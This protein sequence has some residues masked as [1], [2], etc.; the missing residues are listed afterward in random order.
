MNNPTLSTFKLT[1]LSKSL[2]FFGKH[3]TILFSLGLVAGLGRAIQLE[4]F[5]EISTGVHIILE[6]GIEFT[7]ALI[8]LYVL[9]FAN[10]RRGAIRL[11]DLLLFSPRIK[12]QWRDAFRTFKIQWISVLLN[13]LAFSCIAFALNFWIDLT[14]YDTCFYANLKQD[15]IISETA[16][17]WVM[18]LFLK[19][20]SVIPFTL[21]FNAIFMLWLSR[22]LVADD[23]LDAAKTIKKS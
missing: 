3:F 11:K 4:S 13:L 2:S 7:R 17:E 19:N 20:I 22:K 14:V 6:I 16:S 23:S 1:W 15:G 10:I 9:G 18:I 5:G 21:V 12:Q 8:F